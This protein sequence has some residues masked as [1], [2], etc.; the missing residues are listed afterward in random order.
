MTAFK[1]NIAKLKDN[2][3]NYHKNV[4]N[5]KDDFGSIYAN[6]RNVDTCWNDA[7]ATS[8][9][10]EI[11]SDKYKLD[12][13]FESIDSLYKQVE[14][15]QLSFEKLLGGYGYNRASVINYNDDNYMSSLQSFKNAIANLDSALAYLNSCNF[16]ATFPE[17][18]KVYQVRAEIKKLRESINNL[19]ELV[20][21]FKKSVDK[22]LSDVKT[23]TSKI[24]DISFNIDEKVYNW[25]LLDLD[26]KRIDSD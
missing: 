25:S 9:V 11:K 21:V 3:T 15:L 5:C 8:F 23:N 19:I 17:I 24:D 10:N 4:N 2:V 22:I 26:V 1:L 7:V 18:Y 14:F 12:N 6:L 16:K 20:M 13:Y